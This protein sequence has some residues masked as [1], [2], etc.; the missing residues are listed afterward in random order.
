VIT[1]EATVTYSRGELP[2]TLKLYD[3]LGSMVMDYTSLLQGASGS[4]SISASTLPS[5]VYL[6]HLTGGRY[7]YVI[8]M[9]VE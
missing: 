2:A 6:L 1:A 7:A 4:F 8:R 9:L 3:Q 5:G